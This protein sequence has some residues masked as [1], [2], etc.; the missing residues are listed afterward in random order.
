MPA[1]TH[2]VVDR[3]FGAFRRPGQTLSDAMLDQ[4]RFDSLM[5]KHG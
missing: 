2:S 1:H 3:L 5:E 4:I